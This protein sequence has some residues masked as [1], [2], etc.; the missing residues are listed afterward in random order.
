MVTDLV[1]WKI[2]KD[3]LTGR[4][5]VVSPR[6][7]AVEGPTPQPPPEPRR[8]KPI[9]DFIYSGQWREGYEVQDRMLNE[10]EKEFGL[11]KRICEKDAGTNSVLVCSTIKMP[12]VPI[13]SLA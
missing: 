13:F 6:A 7:N 3:E 2:T 11:E 10:F 9:S 1:T 4:M 12:E 8:A 5:A